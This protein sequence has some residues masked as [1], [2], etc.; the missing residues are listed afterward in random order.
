VYALTIA[1]RPSSSC[2]TDPRSTLVTGL[3]LCCVPPAPGIATASD[4]D[5]TS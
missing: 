1:L 2:M 5:L 4:D 3:A